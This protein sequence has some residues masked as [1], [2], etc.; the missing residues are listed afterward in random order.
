VGII[1]ALLVVD[2]LGWDLRAWFSD[3]WDTLS[4]IPLQY[5][6]GGVALQGAQ[7]TFTALAWLFILRAAYTE[8]EI[9]FAP[10][11]ASYAVG[12]AL[13]NVVPANLGTLA[14]LFMFVA[15]IPRATFAGVFAGYLVHKIFFTVAGTVVYLYLFLS[16]PGSFSIELGALDA[17]PVLTIVIIVGGI[18]L[19]VLL[20][21]IFWRKLQGLWE[22]AKE[23]GAILATPRKY[24]IRV[25][26]PSFVAWLAKLGV[27]AVFLAAYSIPVTFHTVMS[28]VGGNSLANTVS[29]TPGGVGVN[30]AVNAAALS[31]VVD[32][33]TATAYSIGQQLAVTAWNILFGLALVVWAF[34]W[35]GGKQLVQESYEEAK[36]KAAEQKAQRAARRDEKRSERTAAGEDRRWLRRSRATARSDGEQGDGGDGGGS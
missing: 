25:V 19:L 24:A 30:Q 35:T 14:M 1:V 32:T 12:V 17:H 23:G 28:V 4:E 21:R 13:N 8:V 16:V 33:A 5:I 36:D 3:F 27:I 34:G 29:A 26:L 18:G 22:K 20:C 15:I 31:D 10:I 2:L 9:P 7:T 6:L 11:L